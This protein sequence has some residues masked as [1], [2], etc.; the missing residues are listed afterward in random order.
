MESKDIR[1]QKTK[2]S[3]ED[4]FLSLIKEKSFT[5]ITIKDLCD[6]AMIS[7]STFYAHYKDKYDLL[8]YFF[9]KIIS[10]FTEITSNYFCKKSMSI[11]IEHASILLNYIYDNADIFN[12]FLQLNE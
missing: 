6:K 12:T 4:A 1:I 7:R 8:E 10:N 5:D 9:K 11:K 2:K 3:I